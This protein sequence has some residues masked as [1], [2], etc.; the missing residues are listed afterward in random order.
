VAYVIGGWTL[1]VASPV[2]A[3]LPGP[4]GVAAAAAGLVLILRHSP[5]SR[6]TFVRLSRRYPRV[7]MPVRRML[8]QGFRPPSPRDLANLPRQAAGAIRRLFRRKRQA[9]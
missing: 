8:K 1:I 7:L 2:I 5:R 6:R 9:A 3:P 4:G